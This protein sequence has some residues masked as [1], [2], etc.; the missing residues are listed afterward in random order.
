[1]RN[2]QLRRFLH[3]QFGFIPFERADEQAHVC[4]ALLIGGA[5]PHHAAQHFAFADVRNDGVVLRAAAVQ[6]NHF[7]ALLQAQNVLCVRIF[8]AR[9]HR[10]ARYALYKK[11]AYRCHV[12]CPLPA[13]SPFVFCPLPAPWRRLVFAESEREPFAAAALGDLFQP[14]RR[15]GV[16]DLRQFG[17][18]DAA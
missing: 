13:F 10:F 17:G 9:K 1:M 14:D 6:K 5:L 4:T 3:D 8:V 11:S 18:D 7:V 16:Y 12:F 2:A 15:V